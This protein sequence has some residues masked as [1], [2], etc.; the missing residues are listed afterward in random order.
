MSDASDNLVLEHLRALRSDMSDAR[1]RDKEVL[2]R[3]S[4]IE[5]LLAVMHSD[6][7]RVGSRVDDHEERL[8]RIEKRAGL[9]EADA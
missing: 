4:S 8:E 2:A 6:I 1:K 9:I 5:S 3:L 7:V